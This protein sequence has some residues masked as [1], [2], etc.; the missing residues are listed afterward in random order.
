PLDPL[1]PLD[2]PPAPVPPFIPCPAPATNIPL[3]LEPPSEEPLPPF[4]ALFAP[5]A[6][7]AWLAQPRTQGVAT[8]N[9]GMQTQ[10]KVS[11]HR[12][13]DLSLPRVRPFRTGGYRLRPTAPATEDF[14][15][16]SY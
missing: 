10:V 14:A 9:A 15:D 12:A 3:P 2:P 4:P 13:T 6:S 16:M 11:N 5:L 1:D 8:A 7:S